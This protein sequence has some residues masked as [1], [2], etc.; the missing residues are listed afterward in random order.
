MN[1]FI[2]VAYGGLNVFPRPRLG[3]RIGYLKEGSFVLQLVH[4]VHHERTSMCVTR[5]IVCLTSM[6]IGWV[7]IEDKGDGKDLNYRHVYLEEFKS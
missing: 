2:V 1:L 4:G 6:G 7:P 3:T 5:W